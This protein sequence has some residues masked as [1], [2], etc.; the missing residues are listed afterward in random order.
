[1]F[2]IIMSL[3]QYLIKIQLVCDDKTLFSKLNLDDYF[4]KVFFSVKAVIVSMLLYCVFS[5]KE[6]F[7][8]FFHFRRLIF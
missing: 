4:Y 1:M 8:F 2:L 6:F 3:K 5:A 7:F